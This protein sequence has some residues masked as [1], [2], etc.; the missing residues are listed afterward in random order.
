MREDP[1]MTSVAE[2]KAAADP[3]FTVPL[4]KKAYPGDEIDVP[5]RYY[6]GSNVFAMFAADPAAVDAKLAGTGLI[7]AMRIGRKPLVV[8][9]I[10]EYRQSS[11]GPYNEVGVAILVYPERFRRSRSVLGWRDVLR[12]TDRRE[13]GVYIIDLPVTTPNAYEAGCAIWGFPKFVAPISFAL[14]GGHFSSTV[15]DTTDGSTI[16]EFSG[17]AKPTVKVPPISLV[18]YSEIDDKPVRSSIEVRNGMRLHVPGGINLKVGQSRHRMANNLRDLGLDG[19]QP[20]AVGS[21][22]NFQS[23]LDVPAPRFI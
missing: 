9:S 3:F 21:T 23:R 14:G 1:K 10:Y 22:A 7:P 12:R 8:V 15:E 13:Q 19:A 20:V 4:N 11:I 2:T 16:M 18:C 6:D 17:A 5:I